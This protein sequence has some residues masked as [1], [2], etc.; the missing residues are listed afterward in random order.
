[1]WAIWRYQFRRPTLISV[2]CASFLVGIGLA[3]GFQLS[4]A[5]LALITLPACLAIKRKSLLIVLMVGVLGCGLG[6]WRGSTVH[7]SLH[8]HD[9]VIGHKI[10]ILT[11][12]KGDAVYGYNSQL[13]F[14]GAGSMLNAGGKLPGAVQISGFG[15][16]AVYAGDVVAVT[17]KLYPGRGHYNYRLSY[18][19]LAVVKHHTNLIM[20]LKRKFTAGMT[21]ALPEPQAS[22]AMGLLIGQRTSLPADVKQA[23]LMVGLTHII[24]VSGY[25]L[26]IMLNASQRILGSRSKR[27]S[28]GMA[29]LLMSTFLLFTGFSASIVRAAIVSMLSIWATY[30]GRAFKPLNLI[31]VAAAITAWANPAYVWSDASWY[32]SFLAFFGVLV[33]APLLKRGWTTR[34]RQSLLIG[35]ALESVCAELMTLPYVLY[36][37]GQMSL[38]GLPAN[39]L[40]VTLIP[41]AM[42]MSLIAGLSG[43]VI[44]QVA[45]WFAL[46]AKLLL[47]YMLDVAQTLSG[48]PHI[49]LQNL[50]LSEVAM[51]LLYLALGLF[52][53]VLRFKKVSRNV[54]ITDNT[55]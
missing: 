22:F 23:L 13:T 24:A 34:W 35:V 45:G 41:A 19:T 12:A 47:V 43:M 32:L 55:G 11:T 20:G 36:T 17:G 52:V 21:S 48:L 14:D 30:Y 40:V 33:L 2:G 50:S 9:A 29:I 27:V 38:V 46:P 3:A 5:Y 37:F 49:F 42:L 1:M 7:R 31:L 15:A 51:I 28:T 6:L 26:T 10:T 53:A 25:N 18:A 16:N 8:E 39:V 44:P 54:T 4:G